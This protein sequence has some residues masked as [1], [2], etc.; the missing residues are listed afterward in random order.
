[1]RIILL[2]FPICLFSQKVVVRDIRTELSLETHLTGSPKAYNDLLVRNKPEFS[3]M[4]RAAQEF[5]W[6]RQE[7]NVGYT[8]LD[9]GVIQVKNGFGY[10]DRKNAIFVYP[11]FMNARLKGYPFFAYNTPIGVE[12]F[13][14]H[15][16]FEVD[17]YTDTFSFSTKFRK[18][19]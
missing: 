18:S 19:I 2:F 15:W 8:F 14:G 16:A 17:F 1:M 9:R 13:L 10:R 3:L 11:F 6:I 12:F 4:F 5:K 7:I